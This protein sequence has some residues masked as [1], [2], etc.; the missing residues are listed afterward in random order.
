MSLS[1]LKQLPVIPLKLTL[2][3]GIDYHFKKLCLLIR[4]VVINRNLLRIY[5][6]YKV[7]NSVKQMSLMN[8]MRVFFP[9]K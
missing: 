8:S 2:H 3:F 9:T 1:L 6:L 5:Q 7:G 4:Q